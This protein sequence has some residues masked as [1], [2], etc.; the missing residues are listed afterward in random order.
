LLYSAKSLWRTRVGDEKVN[1]VDVALLGATGIVGQV[2]LWILANHDYFKLSFV[3]ASSTKKGKRISEAVQWLLPYP[4]PEKIKDINLKELDYSQLESS[5]ARIVFSAL[6]SDVS[7]DVEPYLREIGFQVFSNSGAMR[8]DPD[9]P[10]LIP[11]ANIGAMK[12]VKRQKSKKGGFIVTNANCSVTGLAIALA[13]LK[14]FGIS[15]VFVSTY[16]SI[17]G[18]GYPGISAVD[19]LNNAV[20]HIENEED[21]IIFELKKILDIEAEIFPHCVR[22]PTIFGH[23]ENVWI[24]FENDVTTDEVVKAWEVYCLKDYNVPSLPD[25]P[26]IYCGEM[27]RPQPRMSFLGDPQ[28]MQIFTG[29]IR[30][31]SNMLG[32]TLLVN[33]I[34]RGAAGGSVLNAELFVKYFRSKL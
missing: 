27:N 3:A 4:L 30:K 21:K 5:N 7:M 8:H 34:V 20:P 22:I 26:V 31:L 28:G 23:L 19:I 17:S 12:L 13:P 11:E 33:N 6:P 2:F 32:F 1:K 25:R 14:K 29:R 15:R 16:Q 9:V 10:I 24:E 18:A